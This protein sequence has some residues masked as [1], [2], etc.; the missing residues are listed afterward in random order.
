MIIE[1][2]ISNLINR[3]TS[4]DKISWMNSNAAGDAEDFPVGIDDCFHWLREVDVDHP[5]P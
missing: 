1:N 5:D 2:D 3:R 4:H